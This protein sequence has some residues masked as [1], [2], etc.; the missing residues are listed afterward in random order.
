MK[1]V[2]SKYQ[3]VPFWSW[4][5]DLQEEGLVKQIKWMK[6]VGI[7]GFFMHARGGLTTPYL[8][9]KWFSCVRA[10]EKAA[11]ELNM[12]AYAYDENGWPSGF[13]GGKL[14]ED[15]ENHDRYFTYTLGAYDKDA[16]VS[17]DMSGDALVKV[18]SG[19]NCLNVFMHYSTSTADILND[20]VMDKF[21]ELTH[22]Q[23]KKNDVYKNLRGFFTDEPQYFRWGTPTTKKVFEYF[24]EVYGENLEDKVGLLF[25]EKEGY[26]ELRYKYWKAM[27]TLMLK[28]WA[29]KIYDWCDSNGYKLTGHYVEEVSMAMQ[30]MCNAGIMPFYEYEHIPGMDWLG[31]YV[32]TPIAPKQVGSVC[33]QLGKKQVL[34]EMFAC[35]GW[36][37]NPKELKQLAEFMYVDGVN[38]MCQHLLPYKENGQRKRDYPSHFSSVNPWIEKNFKEFNDYFSV[39]GELLANSTEK[40]N[41]AVLQPI[42]SV[43]FNYKR[44]DMDGSCADI[45][46]PFR[47]LVFK[48]SN[49]HIPYHFVDETLLAK[50]GKVENKQLIMGLCK[51]DFVILPKIYTMDKTTE[52]LLKEYVAQGGKILLAGDKPEYLEWTPY[53]YPY[54]KTNTSFKEMIDQLDFFA[55]EKDDIRISYRL[56]KEGKPYLYVVNCKEDNNIKITVKGYKSFKSYNILKDEYEII[57]GDLFLEKGQSYILYFSNEE[58]KEDKKLSP[59]TLKDEYEVVGEVENYMTLDYPRYSTDDKN[60]SEPL[61][62]MGIFNTLLETRYKGDLYLKYEFDVK[63]VPSIC[64]ALIEK[65]NIKEVYVNGTKVESAGL[66][67]DDELLE[68]KA[69]SLLKV[70]KNEVKVVMNYWQSENVYYALFGEGVTE[71]L[72]N[73]LAY[74]SNVEA[75][76]LKGNFG[77]FGDF[78]KGIRDDI[79]IGEN[80]YLAKQKKQ[81]T[82]LIRDGYPF[83]FG[84]IHLRQEVEVED[85]NK[86]LYFDRRF[87]L[88]D[89]SLNNGEPQRMMFSSRLDLSKELK[90]GKNVFDLVLTVSKRNQMGPHHTPGQEDFGIGPYSWERIGTWKNGKSSIV[91]DSYSFVKSII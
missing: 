33:A 57:S 53:D 39:L 79:E 11:Q 35:C 3:S 77:V 52:A 25:V 13:V 83:L 85:T 41:V 90:K 61:H 28:N 59:L 51:Y 73:C 43:Y 18:T 27:Q 47:E 7:G 86:Y 68:Y 15:I 60:Y 49:K 26:R 81:V 21:L 80:F 91:R 37:V 48:L 38:L 20:E 50:Y 22:E 87:H 89:V 4:N 56:D 6:E 74:D 76:Y 23:Y 84:D 69:A 32:G 54:L 40:V 42:R 8:G 78:S 14:L 64:S 17:Y 30:M 29:K 10:C 36:D 58:V 5:S 82:N 19:D 88:I 24:K 46:N 75:I 9:E 45:D 62:Y 63:E 2:D 44:D 12:E 55:E 1:K 67:A 70:G 66:V 31:R 65:E 16:L 72:R 34:S 71:S